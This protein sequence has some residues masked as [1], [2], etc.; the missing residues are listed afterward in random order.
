MECLF[1]TSQC[2]LKRGQ[3]F[4]PQQSHAFL[5]DD[6]RLIFDVPLGDLPH[7]RPCF[8]VAVVLDFLSFRLYDG[9][10]SP[11]TTLPPL[12]Y[13]I[14]LVSDTMMLDLLRN[15]WCSSPHLGEEALLR[16]FFAIV[17]V[18]YAEEAKYSPR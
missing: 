2:D 8:G 16:L 9:E 5:N 11:I 18:G 3:F 12:I 10:A 15:V 6:L 1:L 13:P 17:R 7:V 14:H 4:A